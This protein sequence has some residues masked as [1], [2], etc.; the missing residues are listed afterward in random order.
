MAVCGQCGRRMTVRY[1]G[2]DSAC[3]VYCCLADRNQTGHAV[4]WP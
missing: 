2:P 4:L 1:S 3:S